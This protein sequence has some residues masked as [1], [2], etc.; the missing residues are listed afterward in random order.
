VIRFSTYGH[1]HKEDI[2][3][4]RAV[5]SDLA[6][7]INFWTSSVSTFKDTNPSFRVFEVDV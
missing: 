4:F 1:V 5:N 2:G 6:V 7:G 3:T